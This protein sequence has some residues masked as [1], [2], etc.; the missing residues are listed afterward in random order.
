MIRYEREA[1][2]QVSRQYVRQYQ[3]K[4]DKKYKK[5]NAM[6]DEKFG[7]RQNNLT[8]KTENNTKQHGKIMQRQGVI[9]NLDPGF[10]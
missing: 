8:S 6:L 3:K 1:Q 4:Q 9:Y 2:S 5:T 10:G 7:G